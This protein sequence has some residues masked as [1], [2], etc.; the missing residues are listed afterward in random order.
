MKNNRE[1]KIAIGL[2]IIMITVCLV[3]IMIAKSGNTKAE[4]I[5]LKVYKLNTS[6]AEMKDYYYE[7]C[8]IATDDLVRINKEYK[9][10]YK[11]EDKDKITGTKIMGEYKLMQGKNYIAFDKSDEKTF[12]LYR[13]DTSSLYEYESILNK[14]VVKACGE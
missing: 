10:T 14:L 2:G 11:L 6:A 3:A 9:K 4:E 1:V 5:D 8:K 13:S 7:E 12:S